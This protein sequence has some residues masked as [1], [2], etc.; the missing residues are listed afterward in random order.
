LREPKGSYAK[1]ILTYVWEREM[2]WAT[3]LPHDI[4]IIQDFMKEIDSFI[5]GAWGALYAR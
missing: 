2:W 1:Y 5:N 3:T 4:T